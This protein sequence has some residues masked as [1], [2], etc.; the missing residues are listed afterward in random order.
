MYTRARARPHACV[1]CTH[2][3]L[4]N[5][6]HRMYDTDDPARR[7]ED[8]LSYKYQTGVT[9]QLAS[10]IVGGFWR[11]VSDRGD[12]EINVAANLSRLTTKQ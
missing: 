9:R 1:A 11:I 7:R 4:C 10:G 2:I 3:Q 12:E 6:T 8:K 5:S